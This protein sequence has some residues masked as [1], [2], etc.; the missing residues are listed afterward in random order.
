[1][2]E[3]FRTVRKE[4]KANARKRTKMKNEM[5]KV[6]TN[7]VRT[8]SV[9]IDNS[10]DSKNAISYLESIKNETVNATNKILY[11]LLVLRGQKFNYDDSVRENMDEELKNI[12]TNKNVDFNEVK[13]VGVEFYNYI[14]A[15]STK[16]TELVG[17]LTNE[18]PPKRTRTKEESREWKINKEKKRLGV[19]VLPEKEIEKINKK[20]D[21]KRHVEEFLILREAGIFP[22]LTNTFEKNRYSITYEVFCKIR[23]FE[24]FTKGYKANKEKWIKTLEEK[25]PKMEHLPRIAEFLSGIN[26]DVGFLK[27]N[28]N[29]FSKFIRKWKNAQDENGSML[30]LFRQ[31]LAEHGENYKFNEVDNCLYGYSHKFLNYVF[32]FK[33]L[34][35]KDDIL[36]SED[37]LE[38]I[39]ES[40]Y[41]NKETIRFSSVKEPIYHLGINYIT[42]SLDVKNGKFVLTFGHKANGESKE[43]KINCLSSTYFNNVR[44]EKSTDK[45]EEDSEGKYKIY[46]STDRKGKRH[47]NASI[48]EPAIRYN[49]EKNCWVLDIMMS[50]VECEETKISDSKELDQTHVYFKEASLIGTNQKE[51]HKI[52]IEMPFKCMGVDLGLNPIATVTIASYDGHN[53]KFDNEQIQIGKSTTNEYGHFIDLKNKIIA[54]KKLISATY[55]YKN[56]LADSIP[57]VFGEKGRRQYHWVNV[58]G[59]SYEEYIENVKALPVNKERPSLTILEWRKKATS[60]LIKDTVYKI[61]KEMDAIRGRF[62]TIKWEDYLKDNHVDFSR[63]LWE[64][65]IEEYI[66]LQKCITFKGFNDEDR[67]EYYRRNKGRICA[68]W[69]EHIDGLRRKRELEISSAIINIAIENKVRIIAVEDLNIKTTSYDNKDRNKM[70][71]LW[72]VGSFIKRLED[73]AKKHNITILFVNPCATSQID[74]ETGLYGYRDPD[75]KENLY[76]LRN[77]K[78]EIIN[79]D[80]NASKNIIKRM[81]C[82]HDDLTEFYAKIDKE[83]NN[84][85]IIAPTAKQRLASMRNKFGNDAVILKA[86]S[87]GTLSIE[88]K[89]PSRKDI[90]ISTLSKGTY[91]AV[92]GSEIKLKEVLKKEL[93]ELKNRHDCEN[94]KEK[95]L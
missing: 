46:Y 43:S 47:Y 25:S 64:E 57:S 22:V 17:F 18:N 34:W 70:K 48:K 12:I 20:I 41:W 63:I 37:Y 3:C 62:N 83:D 8:S 73:Q 1:M 35:E 51:K 59:F 29:K 42:F 36:G 84:R 82:R 69:Y 28:K 13:R 58:F 45:D 79:S 19:D 77:G 66:S 52:A 30:D 10:Q 90:D 23:S 91:I 49:S 72:G 27:I 94:A 39:E 89:N 40:F 86:Q 56:N 61:N 60:W 16:A 4:K 7:K 33:D 26:E 6:S 88:N 38:I 71:T 15:S 55:A 92:N 95:I 85:Y 9:K 11:S 32:S 50:N 65:V 53:L 68:D 81:I 21:G 74:N 31:R 75:R 14:T 44:L 93:I 24:E 2:V 78:I 67:K 5:F 80:E 54:I 76:V 87:D